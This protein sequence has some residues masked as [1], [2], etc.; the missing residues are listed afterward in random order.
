M[1]QFDNYQFEDDESIVA[2]R[3]RS[4]TPPNH[5]TDR[6]QVNTFFLFISSYFI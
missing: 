2:S 6:K 3:A 1:N 4:H 5:H